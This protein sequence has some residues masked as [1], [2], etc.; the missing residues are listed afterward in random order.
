MA[1]NL[2]PDDVEDFIARHVDSIAQLEALLILRAF[3]DKQWDVREISKRLYIS[4]TDTLVV[5]SRLSAD[6][7]VV[8]VGDNY[9]YACDNEK[10][11]QTI[12]RLAQAYSKHLIPVTNMI[13]AKPSK[14]REFSDA[15]KIRRD[16]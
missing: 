1:N 10:A 9:R 14:I 12:E 5:L 4:Q 8:A 15:F 3:S 7:F 13:H 6:G 11:R 16:P 2:I